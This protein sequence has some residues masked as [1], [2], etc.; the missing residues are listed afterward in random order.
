MHDDTRSASGGRDGHDAHDDHRRTLLHVI[1]KFSMSDGHPSSC[2]KLL[3]DWAELHDPGRFAVHFCGLQ[4]DGGGRYLEERG[5]LVHYI[6]RGKVSPAIASDIAALAR[7]LGADLLHLH[8]YSAANF[9][10]LAGRRLGIPAVV[11]EHAILKVKPHQ[12]L[13]DL[14]LRGHTDCGVA[15][16]NAVR[17]FMVRGRCVPRR[18]IEVIHNGIRLERFAEVAPERVAALRTALGI[19]EDAVVIGTVT[20]LREEKGNRYL[21]DAAARLLRQF[22]QAVVL[23]L[24]DGPERADL[25]ARARRHGI[26][27]GRLRMPGFQE[28]VPAALALMRIAVVPSIREGLSLA[29][30]EAMAAGKPIVATC[31]GGIL[32]LVAHEETAILVPPADGDALAAGVARLLSSPEEAATLA[33]R[34]CERSRSFS[35]EHN[36]ERLEALYERLISEHARSQ[37]G[38][39]GQRI[40]A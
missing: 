27:P 13:A 10:R 23:V 36:V 7:H 31:V 39:R 17:E 28:D 34:A 3:A 9:G 33:A 2:T 32:E 38:A 22:P 24:G 11:H 40:A 29:V 5:H 25:E 37:A 35:I 8:G 16:S 18:R 20:R 12:F 4:R 19:A 14:A 15:I 21:I 1:D 26:D 6:E 30:L